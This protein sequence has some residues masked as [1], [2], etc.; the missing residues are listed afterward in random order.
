MWK[1]HMNDVLRTM[2][3]TQ[4]HYGADPG[5]SILLYFFLISIWLFRYDYII[6]FLSNLDNGSAHVC[7]LMK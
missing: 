6:E 4:E 2:W 5:V 7:F 1:Y 3:R